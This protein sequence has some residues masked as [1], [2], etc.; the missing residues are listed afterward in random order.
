MNTNTKDKAMM[1]QETEC[2]LLDRLADDASKWAAEFRKT[3][4]SLG[5]SDMDEGWLITWFANA[6]EHSSDVRRLTSPPAPQAGEIERASIAI[7][8]SAKFETGEGTCALLCMDQLGDP[9]KNGCHH[10]TT[11]HKLLAESVL[12]ALRSTQPPARAYADVENDLS[13]IES[14]AQDALDCRADRTLALR[15]IVNR[16]ARALAN[17]ASG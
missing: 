1:G 14:L 10:A 8:K 6:I 2:Q 4:T 11:V 13:V 16:C 17:K 15:D 5:Y 7:C 3:A 12:A 9:R